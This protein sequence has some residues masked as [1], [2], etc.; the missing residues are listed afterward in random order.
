M[1]ED[2]PGACLPVRG[3]VSRG[4][5]STGNRQGDLPGR[6]ERGQTH[7]DHPVGKVRAQDFGRLH[8]QAG[9]AHAARPEHCAAT[10]RQSGPLRRLHRSASSAARPISTVGGT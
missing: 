5:H 2:G 8:R 4:S 7:Q 9:L 6:T 10:S 1:S 3:R